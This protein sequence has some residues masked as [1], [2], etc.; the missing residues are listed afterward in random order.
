MCFWAC[1]VQHH[2]YIALAQVFFQV[3]RGE[4]DMAARMKD[5]DKIKA[6]HKEFYE[7]SVEMVEVLDIKENGRGGLIGITL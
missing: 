5:L 7:L 6:A 2:V 3:T 1:A 4:M